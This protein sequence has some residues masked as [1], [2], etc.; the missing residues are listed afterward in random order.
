[1]Y[2][3]S[4]GCRSSITS[5]VICSANLSA[6]SFKSFLLQYSLS[7]ISIEFFRCIQKLRGAFANQSLSLIGFITRS[8]NSYLLLNVSN[9]HT[10]FVSGN[11]GVRASDPYIT[12][13]GFT[14]GSTVSLPNT[15]VSSPN[16][17]CGTFGS[18]IAMDGI[19]LLPSKFLIC[20]IKFSTSMLLRATKSL[21]AFS[22]FFAVCLALASS[23]P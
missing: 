15:N 8:T 11:V 16:H 13:S 19:G 6:F 2:S 23:I 1:M 10:D 12:L 17:S 7:H 5:S 22:D 9:V 18:V 4:P 3:L 20:F 14:L 21:V